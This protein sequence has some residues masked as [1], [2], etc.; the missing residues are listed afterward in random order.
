M[1]L[2]RKQK[3]DIICMKTNRKLSLSKNLSINKKTFN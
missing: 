3:V 1:D 2:T